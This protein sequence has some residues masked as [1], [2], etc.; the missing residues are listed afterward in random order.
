MTTTSEHELTNIDSYFD[1]FLLAEQLESYLHYD[2]DLNTAMVLINVHHT[3][4]ISAHHGFDSAHEILSILSKSLGEYVKDGGDLFRTGNHEFCLILQNIKNPGHCQLAINS[5]ERKL[6]NKT[7]SGKSFTTKTRLTISAALYP[8][9][10][11]TSEHLI[12]CA[13]IALYQAEQSHQS[14][15]IYSEMM[16]NRIEKQLKIESELDLAINRKSLE[17]WFQPKLDLHTNNLYGVEVLTRWQTRGSGFIS[18]EIF[19]PIAEQSVL[20]KELT[21]WALNTAFSTQQEW[22][23]I[24]LPL[25]FAINISGKVV[26][27]DEFVELVEHTSGIWGVKPNMVTIEVTE[28]AMMQSFESSMDKL[29]HLKDLGFHI[30]IDDFGT[31][32]SS[33]EYFK[34]LPVSEIKIDKSFVINM[35]DN[36]ADRK[37]VSMIAGLSRG[38]GLKIVAEGVEN[39]ASLDALRSLG[40]HRAQGF[41]ISKPMPEDEFL[42]WA[43]FYLTNLELDNSV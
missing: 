19:I 8:K 26:D 27:D 40:V 35:M 28:T 22:A 5:I 16:S 23:K 39:E 9:H 30:S 18:P 41:H 14:H 3:R 17:M 38:F 29:R 12:Q 36:E 6:N 1:R 7:L 15:L 20:I 33:L 42:T 34:N 4:Q 11:I 10:A 21:H 31:G 13:E 2:E 37:M 24:G 25:N 43:E 32:Y